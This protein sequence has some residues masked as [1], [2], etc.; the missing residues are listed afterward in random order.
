MLSARAT[1]ETVSDATTATPTAATTLRIFRMC[2]DPL[3]GSSDNQ[4]RTKVG[5]RGDIPCIESPRTQGELS[6]NDQ[7]N[8][9]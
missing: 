5:L 6:V 7:P 9:Q 2:F 8:F 1:E 4:D 3:F